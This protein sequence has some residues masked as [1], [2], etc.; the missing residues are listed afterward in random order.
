MQRRYFV[1]KEKSGLNDGYFAGAIRQLNTSSLDKRLH[2]LAPRRTKR[3]WSVRAET[4]NFKQASEECSPV[5][6]NKRNVKG[7]IS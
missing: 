2:R 5:Q 6:L 3:D 7:G 1:S 4:M